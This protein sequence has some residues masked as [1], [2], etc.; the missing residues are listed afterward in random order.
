MKRLMLVVT[1][2]SLLFVF[3]ACRQK[4][5]PAQQ[6]PAAIDAAHN[7]QNSLTWGGTYTGT[8]RGANSQDIEIEIIL[9]YDGSYI[10][11]YHYAF[12]NSAVINRS[13]KFRWDDMGNNIMLDGNDIP[14]YYKVGEY[15][16]IQLDSQ[17]NQLADKYELKQTVFKLP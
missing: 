15:K 14:P 12:E 3:A 2:V 10:V 7:S 17:G 9:N 16:L 8:V 1:V 13:G 5:E 4:N 11:T 6:N